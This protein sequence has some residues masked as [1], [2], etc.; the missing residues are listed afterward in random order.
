[1]STLISKK[2]IVSFP[3][4]IYS[5]FNIRRN[6]NLSLHKLCFKKERAKRE[7]GKRG[8]TH[9]CKFFC[10]LHPQLITQLSP[11]FSFPFSIMTMQ[12]YSAGSLQATGTQEMCA[13]WSSATGNSGAIPQLQ[14]SLG[15][16]KQI[17]N[18]LKAQGIP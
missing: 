17:I 4:A 13:P 2:S 8:R 12:S 7:R 14:N 3:L 15:Q 10:I 1:M 18:H 11:A 9:K 16:L 6:C 5:H